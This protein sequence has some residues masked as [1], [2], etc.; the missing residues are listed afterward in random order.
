MIVAADVG[1]TFTDVVV[2]DGAAPIIRK[3]R[4]TAVQSDAI[5]AVL[6][7]L[8]THSSDVGVLHGTTVATNA[9][10]EK[11]GARTALFT[12]E[13]FEDVLEIGR[14]HR[15]SLY[16]PFLDR[17]E[18]LVTRHDRFG[19]S[20]VSEIRVPSDVE[21]VAV[22][23]IDGHVDPR[24]ERGVRDAI[25]VTHPRLPVSI[26][27]EVAPE[28]REFERVSTTVLNA[29]LVPGTRRYLTQLA[30]DVVEAG[31]AESLA[32]MRSSGGLMSVESAAELPAAILLS[33]PAG[34]A[35]AA[36][37]VAQLLGHD[38]VV[39]FDMGGTST[40]VCRIE[41]GRIDASSERSIDGYVCRM[42][43]VAI[44]TVG[45]GGGS[46]AWIDSGGSLR[47]GP[48]SAGADPGP[49]CY[50]LGGVDATVTDANVVLGRIDAG[51]QF[52][53]AVAIDE[54][55]SEE[56]V[57][58]LATR[59][60]L[61][62]TQT[63]LGIVRI[64]EEVMAGAVR[65]VS[66]EEGVDPAGAWLVAFGGAGGLHASAIAR[67]LDMAG[68]VIPPH[69]GVFS[70]IGLLLA[71]PRSDVVAAV[72]IIDGEL[73]PAA[74]AAERIAEQATSE[75]RAA[76]HDVTTLEFHLDVRYLGQAHEISVPWAPGDLMP[77]VRERFEVAHV[78][79]N[80]FSRPDDALEIVAIRCTAT[81]TPP[82][83]GLRS[84][85]SDGD[86]SPP[87]SRE[88]VSNGGD[89]V[90]AWVVDRSSLV[91]G[92]RLAGP[93]VIEADDATAYLGLGDRA[94]VKAGGS[95][96]VTW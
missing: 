36:R 43:S 65:T 95:I 37:S 31:R 11:S 62:L 20:D 34:G 41:S 15:P 83:D 73:E 50:G 96:E 90:E 32:V 91:P 2:V 3:I 75:L 7:D 17:S 13:G 49:A 74:A 57:G 53:E 94:E 27:S 66:V 21:S 29:Y 18:P 45:A 42:P 69:A 1:G 44:D 55:R 16:D 92:D 38:R 22:A 30:R 6:D 26:S 35:I 63:A 79:R 54:A 77:A 40:D 89:V 51:A 85:A 47:V 4:S 58:M 59:L 25:R 46:I 84:G 19:I 76:G 52:G 12:D 8:D 60:G 39:S 72:T 23:A 80:G 24:W 88:V 71:P 86:P 67:S 10:L 64:A 68:V 9:L 82:L 56:A 48:H 5:V 87:R 78:R 33:G 93:G 28:F 14:Q 61:D 70:A 81:A